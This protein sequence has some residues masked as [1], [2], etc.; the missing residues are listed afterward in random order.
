M[1]APKTLPNGGESPAAVRVPIPYYNMEKFSGCDPQM[2]H[3]VE[4]CTK[5]KSDFL[6]PPFPKN[7]E[8]L[9][10]Y[11]AESMITSPSNST[12]FQPLS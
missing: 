7:N 5:R 3:Q 1:Q 2:L 12:V 8:T 11:I 6:K 10:S 9:K 4:W